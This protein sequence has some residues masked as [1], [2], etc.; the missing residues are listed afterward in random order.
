MDIVEFLRA[1]YAERRALAEAAT[2]PSGWEIR[3]NHSDY[4]P[5]W[6]VC[7]VSDGGTIA[8]VIGDGWEGGGVWHEADARFIAANGPA[9]V[10]ADL[11]AKERIIEEAYAARENWRHGAGTMGTTEEVARATERRDVLTFVARLLAAPYAD[12]PDYGPAWA[13]DD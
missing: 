13:L 12:H 6:E 8:E 5:A 2:V 7:G 9:Y 11:A 10:L 3:P 4:A 1:R